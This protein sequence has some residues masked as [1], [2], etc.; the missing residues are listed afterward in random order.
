[1][2]GLLWDSLIA[3]HGTRRFADLGNEPERI[4][5][6]QL[7]AIEFWVNWYRKGRIDLCNLASKAGLGDALIQPVHSLAMMTDEKAA[8]ALRH[9]TNLMR[10][11]VYLL[12]LV[13][14]LYSF[15]HSRENTLELLKNCS[16]SVICADLQVAIEAESAEQY[17]AALNQLSAIQEKRRCS[18]S[19]RCCWTKSANARLR[20]RTVSAI[21]RVSTETLL[22]RRIS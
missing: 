8:A 20:G 10:P 18:A 1:M 13:N 22:Y 3:A 19:A 16:D 9:I 5:H 7:K 17:E 21:G 4:C 6:Q 14:A 12:H 2:L 15:T 11:A